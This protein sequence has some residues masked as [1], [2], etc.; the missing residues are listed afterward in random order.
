[1]ITTSLCVWP[2][3]ASNKAYLKRLFIDQFRKINILKSIKIWII[4]KTLKNNVLSKIL[5]PKKHSL[6][7]MHKIEELKISRL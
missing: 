6:K 1:L 2:S 5:A 3:L 7:I 4:R